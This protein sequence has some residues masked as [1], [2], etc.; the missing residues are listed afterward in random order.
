MTKECDCYTTILEEIKKIHGD[1]AEWESYTMVL[2]KKLTVMPYM[3]FSIVKK[4]KDGTPLMRKV[5]NH[6]GDVIGEQEV[7]KT[8]SFICSYCPFCG[9][10]LKYESRPR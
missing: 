6:Y 8:V 1:K 3:T 9:K 5:K 10:K 4:R 7:R 2:G